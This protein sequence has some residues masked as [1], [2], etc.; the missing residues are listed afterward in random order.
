MSRFVVG[1]G[2]QLDYDRD[3]NEIVEQNARLSERVAK[4]ESVQRQNSSTSSSVQ[5][6]SR[7]TVVNMGAGSAGASNVSVDIDAPS[8]FLSVGKQILGTALK[9][10]LSYKSQTQNRIFAAPYSND[11]LP[12]FRLLLNDDLPDS[13]VTPGTYDGITV[14]QKGIITAITAG[15]GATNIRLG[16]RYA[17]ST[18]GATVSVPATAVGRIQVK[19]DTGAIDLYLPEPAAS[20]TPDGA[21]FYCFRD[22][23][24]PNTLRF[25]CA[26]AGTMGGATSA[27]M[28][29][30]LP[31]YQDG[32]LF[33]ADKT[34]NNYLVIKL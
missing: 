7:E 10:V 9:F 4:L 31:N 18:S 5:A 1:K 14:N 27:P 33:I 11:G 20:T 3:I 30:D 25:Y 34:T 13:A 22:D 23:Q 21:T 16:G 2:S 8:T 12:D 32:Y 28:Y 15:Y 26:G 17:T 29:I 19:A 24:T 6:S